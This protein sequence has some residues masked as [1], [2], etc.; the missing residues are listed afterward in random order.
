MSVGLTDSDRYEELAAA[1]RRV[2]RKWETNELSSAV[3][4][5]R[6]TLEFHGHDE[7]DP[8]VIAQEEMLAN[9]QAVTGPR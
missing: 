1:S 6:E 2:I 7:E 4:E 8:D 5:L 3:N 9:G